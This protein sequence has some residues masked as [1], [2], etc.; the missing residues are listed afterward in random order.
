MWVGSLLMRH[1]E[2]GDFGLVFAS[3][4]GFKLTSHPD[5]VRAPDVAF[6]VHE[7]LDLGDVVAGW[8]PPVGAFFA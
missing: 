2:D 4:T 1:V 3:A 5:T 6:V 7:T 8:S